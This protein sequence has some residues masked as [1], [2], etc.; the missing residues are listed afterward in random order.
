[1]A[2]RKIFDAA[3]SASE[4]IKTVSKAGYQLL[5]VASQVDTCDQTN[6]PNKTFINLWPIM[7][8]LAV[9]F[10]LL[11]LFVF[12]DKK[13]VVYTTPENVTYFEGVEEY[14][15]VSPDGKW[16]A[17]SWEQQNGT[18]Q[19]FIK[20][21]VPN[22]DTLKQITFESS[23][24]GSPVWSNNS[25]ELAFTRVS[26]QGVCHVIKKDLISGEELP[27]TSCFYER[28]HRGLDWSN[29]G[30][31]LVVT[32]LDANNTPALFQYDLLTGKDTQI[33][34]PS[35]GQ[36]DTQI[37]IHPNI[38][39][40]AFI[41]TKDTLS[42]VYIINEQ[43]KEIRVTELSVPIYGLSWTADGNGLLLNALYRE[44]SRTWIFDLDSKILK[45]L[46][47]DGTSFN[48]AVHPVNK[49]IYYSRH[50]PIEQI[51]KR[52][53]LGEN[54]VIISSSGRDL[55]PSVIDEDMV[56]ISSRSGSFEIWHK[57]LNTHKAKH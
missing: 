7:S 52:N 25:M 10:V 37:S 56:F 28:F 27:L 34:F 55:Y 14:P 48:L 22:D 29:G 50:R 21:L 16:L 11:L 15:S 47:K 57:H 2:L 42:D 17:F 9:V 43:G 20:S 30:K 53:R 5:L 18:G 46:F 45:P 44:E 26:H 54:S 6:Q 49:A 13:E 24:H 39:K 38:D 12:I 40:V 51:V 35:S 19:L 33:S 23:I 3:D 4:S 31:F 32:K 8:V 1:M 36:K 41:R